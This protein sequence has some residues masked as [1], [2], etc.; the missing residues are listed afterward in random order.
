MEEKDM[1]IGTKRACKSRTSGPRLTETLLETE[2]IDRIALR[3]KKSRRRREMIIPDTL[4]KARKLF[5]RI[6]S[7]V[8]PLRPWWC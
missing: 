1:T 6:P 2:T 4:K 7:G 8:R 3:Q 5:P